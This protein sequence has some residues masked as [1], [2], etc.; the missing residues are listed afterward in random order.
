MLAVLF[1][2]GMNSNSIL[3]GFEAKDRSLPFDAEN[4]D[5]IDDNNINQTDA[6]GEIDLGPN[7]ALEAQ[8]KLIQNSGWWSDTINCSKNSSPNIYCKP[9]DKWI[10]P[11]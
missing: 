1:M 11:Y 6:S 7:N 4:F 5:V 2:C 3:F 9:K 8:Q 10:W